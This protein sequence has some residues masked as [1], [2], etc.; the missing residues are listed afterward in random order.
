MDYVFFN[1]I[2][3]IE[4]SITKLEGYYKFSIALTSS[5]FFLRRVYFLY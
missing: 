2:Y 3:I 4:I 1:Q 5:D